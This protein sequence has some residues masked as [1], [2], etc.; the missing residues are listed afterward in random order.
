MDQAGAAG[1]TRVAAADAAGPPPNEERAPAVSQSAHA[2]ASAG[3]PPAVRRT[4]F[5]RHHFLLRRLHSL[6][7][8]V[9]IG[10]FVIF[11][12]FTNFQ[13]VA[14]DFQHEVEFIHNLPALLIMEVTLWASIGFHAGLGLIYTFVGARSNA[15]RYGYGD[16][17]RY[18]FQRVTGILALLFIFFHVAT[19]R[20][21]WDIMGWN[22]P[23][24]AVGAEQ[25]HQL[26]AATTARALQAH[27]LVVVLYIIGSLSVIYHWANGLWT[28]AITWGLT[29]SVQSQRRWGY[30][31]AAV[32]I[33]LTIFFAGAMVGALTYEISPQEQA[34]LE[35]VTQGA[36]H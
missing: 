33:I 19:L 17:W 10:V 28:A 7:G 4:W 29:L 6:T 23:F 1:T 9:P 34:W 15:S 25:S 3:S 18:F 5:D 14:G 32:G 36:Q 16:N 27:W 8:I 24:Y 13:L 26:A 12:L 20:W 2:A 30:V 22:T 11:H 35:A 31:C 21:G